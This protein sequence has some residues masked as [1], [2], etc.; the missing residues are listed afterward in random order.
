MLSI[1]KLLSSFG[2][3]IVHLLLLCYLL[4]RINNNVIYKLLKT[5]VELIYRCNIFF[6][7]ESVHFGM[8]NCNWTS[9]NLRS[10]KI[11]LLSMQMNNANKLMIKI[12]PTKIINL[13]FFNNV[14][15]SFIDFFFML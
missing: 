15:L 14:I 9:M 4:E 5:I 1:I 13:Q 3:I 6:Q 10:K 8:Y 2:T 7:I 11:L 12:T